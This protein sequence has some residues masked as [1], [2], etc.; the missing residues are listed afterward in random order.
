[1]AK[2]FILFYKPY[3]V[4]SQFSNG[5]YSSQ[6]STA[7]GESLTSKQVSSNGGRSAAP[8][9]LKHFIPVPEV[10]PVG[11]LDRDSE[12]LMLLTNH[13]RVQYRLSH[14]RFAHPRTYWV[15]VERIPSFEAIC[16]LR[17]GV[18]IKGY[19]T[20]PCQVELLPENLHLPPRDPP[21]RWRRS[22]PTAWLSM[23]LKEGKNR[24]VRRMTAA[25]GHP[26]LRLVRVALG[27][28]ELGR[29]N[30]GQWRYASE[31]ERR[32]LLAY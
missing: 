4:I 15:Q 6:P 24:Q 20:K 13:G 25:V 27:P 7:A 10:Y 14:P 12:G 19:Q 28:L 31:S 11:R 9:T 8:L 30:P 2:H 32:Q 5:Y 21:I 18:I 17:Q 16:Q 29:L 26:T 23:T 1:M 3:N 22:V